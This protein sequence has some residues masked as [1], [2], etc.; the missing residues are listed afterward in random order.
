[1][2]ADR[3]R[4]EMSKTMPKTEELRDRRDG[5]AKSRVQAAIGRSLKAHYD[6]L[7]HAPIPDKFIELLAKLEMKEQ[8]SASEEDRD[9]ERG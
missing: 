3:A 9:N 7:I 6:D 2:S 8:T 4:V 5:E 1:V